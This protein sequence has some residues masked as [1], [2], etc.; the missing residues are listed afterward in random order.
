MLIGRTRTGHFSFK[1]LPPIER[2]IRNDFLIEGIDDFE[3]HEFL[4]L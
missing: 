4:Y 2:E 1:G 3:M